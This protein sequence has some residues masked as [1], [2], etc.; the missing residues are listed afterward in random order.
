M[1]SINPQNIAKQTVHEILKQLPTKVVDDTIQAF[2]VATPRV[3][4]FLLLSTLHKCADVRRQSI[5]GKQK[6]KAAKSQRRQ[7]SSRSG[8]TL[9]IVVFRQ[10]LIAGR[11]HCE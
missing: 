11:A 5:D 4:S 1:K 6:R 10:I 9:F 2:V 7:S 3:R 8:V